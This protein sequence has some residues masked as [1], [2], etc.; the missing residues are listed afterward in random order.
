MADA[1]MNNSNYF[2]L[3]EPLSEQIERYDYNK[4]GII[5]Q[6]DL[7]SILH[8]GTMDVDDGKIIK[9]ELNSNDFN[10][11]LKIGNNGVEIANEMIRIS[12]ERKSSENCTTI[13]SNMIRFF[14]NTTNNNLVQI[15]SDDIRLSKVTNRYNNGEYTT[16]VNSYI[17]HEKLNVPY[18]ELTQNPT[19]SNHAIRLQ[20]L[21]NRIN[22][23]ILRGTNSIYFEMNIPFVV[24][25]KVFT[26]F[27]Q[28]GGIGI[29]LGGYDI[30]WI[31]SD[32]IDTT[33]NP[34]NTY[35]ITSIWGNCNITALKLN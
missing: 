24:F 9:H 27:P 32:G 25:V 8:I 31:Y 18:V 4:N 2:H 5:D 29:V 14:G 12:D 11:P 35:S 3:S 6:D 1:I 33:R 7:S 28:Y 17:N 13:F 19:A 15:T 26:T 10:F 21:D 30:H 20:D 22:S 23:N 34:D 16:E